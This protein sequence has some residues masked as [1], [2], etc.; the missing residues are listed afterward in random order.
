VRLILIRARY[1]AYRIRQHYDKSTLDKVSELERL[2]DI[3]SGRRALLGY[4]LRSRIAQ[5]MEPSLSNPYVD[6]GNDRDI[7]N[8]DTSSEARSDQPELSDLDRV[9]VF[10]L[11]SAAYH[12]FRQNLRDFVLPRREPEQQDSMSV[13][14][15]SFI[16][17]D[18]W[19]RL[20]TKGVE[21]LH[22]LRMLSK[23][24]VPPGH[25]RI[26]WICVR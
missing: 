15:V 16:S 23:P 19:R 2:N 7:S 18:T 21:V 12:K 9:K 1:I 8:S 26:T 24:L 10:M 13:N 5:G 6:Y 20:Q 22:G 17:L 3:G 14:L 4:Y 25:K 11:E